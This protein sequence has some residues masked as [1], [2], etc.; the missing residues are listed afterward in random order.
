MD[1]PAF[2]RVLAHFNLSKQ[3]YRKVRKG[4]KKRL[5]R[6]MQQV[7]CPDVDTY[8][9]CLK[10]DP[11]AEKQCRVHLTVSI[12]RFFR[13]RRLWETLSEAIV[14][15]LISGFAGALRVWSCGCARG[16][17]VYS[18]RILWDQLHRYRSDL[19]ELVLLGTDI[20]P[21]YVEMAQKG[22]YTLSSLKEVP[23]DICAHYFDKVPGK[24]LFAVKPALKSG[25]RFICHD[26]LQE[27][28]PGRG[29]HLIFLRNSL[30]TYHRSPEKET[31]L[32]GIVRALSPAGALITGAHEKLPEGFEHLLAYPHHPWIYFKSAG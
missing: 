2:H 22:T 9:D 29:F 28:P 10:E 3:G 24:Q 12:S 1:D 16:E 25:I 23:P 31:T 14:P 30:L 15:R 18:F 21:A 6:H 27:P 11:A 8:L 5:S 32:A 7:G 20:N 4:V 26:I 19:P 13:D 17:E